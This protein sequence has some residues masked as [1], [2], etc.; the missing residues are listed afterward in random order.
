MRCTNIPHG[1]GSSP[2]VPTGS[3][4]VAQLGF[5][6]IAF[7]VTEMGDAVVVTREET[8]ED[9][10]VHKLLAEYKEMYPTPSQW[11]REDWVVG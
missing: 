4:V 9:P 6:F 1:A 10:E 3:F 5:E 11:F 2:R 8:S 7:R